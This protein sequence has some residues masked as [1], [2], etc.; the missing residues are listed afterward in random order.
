VYE[1]LL[2]ACCQRRLLGRAVKLFETMLRSQT[3]PSVAA[4][5]TLVL[6]YCVHFLASQRDL[7][8]EG[9][10]GLGA[11]SYAVGPAVMAAMDPD[12]RS[13]MRFLLGIGGYYDLERVVTFFTTGRYKE[14][15]ATAWRIQDPGDYGK[16]VFM[17]SY[18]DRLTDPN[19]SRTLKLMAERK[20]KTPPEDIEDLRATLGA[21]GRSVDTLLNNKDPERV[22]ELLAALPDLA[23]NDLASLNLKGRD[24]SSIEARPIL[25]HGYDD[26]II[27]YTESIALAKALGGRNPR[28]YLANGLAHVDFKDPGLVDIWNLYCAVDTLLAER[29]P[30]PR[31]T[32]GRAGS[33]PRFAW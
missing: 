1:L 16:W 15:D 20:L 8:P 4:Y 10:A 26:I 24:L 30:D 22:P 9:R 11:T 28:L 13:K 29:R 5:S 7:A 21:Q 33:P 6:A 18:S 31:L 19:D 14:G 25:V 17:S 12:V 23:R 27:P 32:A 3:A 2:E